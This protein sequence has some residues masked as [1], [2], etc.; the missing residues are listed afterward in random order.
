MDAFNIAERLGKISRSSVVLDSDRCLHSKDKFS[1]CEACFDVCPVKA[2]SQTK[3]PELNIEDCINCLA[4]LS[5]CPLGAYRADDAIPSLLRCANRAHV[6]SI[7]LLCNYHSN[8]GDGSNGSELGILVHGCLASLG[9]AAYL[10]LALLNFK[11]ITIRDDDCKSCELHSLN[12]YLQRNVERAQF[13]LS[14][15]GGCELKLSTA[16]DLE[17]TATERPLW[18]ADNP[19]LSRRDLFRFASSQGRRAVARSLS[20]EAASSDHLLGRER[21]REIAAIDHLLEENPSNQDIKLDGMG[22]VMLSISDRCSACEACVRICP[23]VALQVKCDKRNFQLIFS[24]RICIACDA[25]QH[26]CSESAIDKDTSPTFQQIFNQGTSIKLF[27]TEL[28]QCEKCGSW[29]PARPDVTLCSLCAYRR[30]NPFG[31]KLPSGL[32]PRMKKDD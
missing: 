28:N 17:G 13:L 15:W 27:E 18:N 14:I 24:P 1:E 31:S 32:F 30:E 5:V 6:D 8:P 29:I 12:E 26:A 20:E 25:C 19:P 10:S 3:P 23:T 4:C 2:I 9:S 11:H 22:Y 7:D 16:G 21:M